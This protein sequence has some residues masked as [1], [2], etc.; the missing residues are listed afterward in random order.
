MEKIFRE[1]KKQPIL[2][3]RKNLNFPPHIH[4]DIE[5]IF[6]K[7]GGGTA[8]CDGKKYRLKENA[9]FLVFPN[10]VHHYNE[11]IKGEYV[12]III[13]PSTL[14]H[15]QSIFE[16]GIPFSALWEWKE[17]YDNN[18][19]SLLDI[20]IEDFLKYGYSPVIEAYLTALFGKLLCF[21]DISKNR[22]SNETI[23][24][25]LQYCGAHYK[26]AITV[27]RVAEKLHISKS[28]V[29]HIFSSRLSI[30]FCD[31]INSLRLTEAEQLLKSKNHSITEISY[32]CGFST[33]RTFNR[34]FIK[35]YG[36]SPSAYRKNAGKTVTETKNDE[37]RKA[38]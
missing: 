7:K 33:I 23:F 12:L 15:Y 8:F 4:D 19:I 14:I 25:I 36:L 16:N 1:I 22:S 29:S 20:I 27:D 17:K 31:Y 32:L 37:T 6:V 38:E 24:Q 11:C 28:T 2:E 34:A 13:K 9:F 18:T 21:Y 30:H 26:E 3:I 10:Q 5:L 35:R